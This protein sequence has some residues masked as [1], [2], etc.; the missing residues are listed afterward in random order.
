M[1]SME[2]FHSWTPKTGGVAQRIAGVVC[3]F[4]VCLV[5]EEQNYRNELAE[6]DLLGWGKVF[7]S[8]KCLK[9]PWDIS[10]VLSGHTK[11]C[12]LSQVL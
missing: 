10:V 2:G 4:Q 5:A 11:Q 8:L 12:Y 6:Q 9:F 3:L 7:F 1:N